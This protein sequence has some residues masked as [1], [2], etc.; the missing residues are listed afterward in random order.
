[1]SSGVGVSVSAEGMAAGFFGDYERS[2]FRDAERKRN[3]AVKGRRDAASGEIGSR[4]DLSRVTDARCLTITS[5]FRPD[6]P[7]SRSRFRGACNGRRNALLNPPHF[8]HGTQTDPM[9]MVTNNGNFSLNRPILCSTAI[10]FRPSLLICCSELSSRR[11]SAVS[12][13]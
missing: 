8:P 11:T 7:N 5:S 12:N 13:P 3:R 10:V 1:M 6:A 2:T 4:R 9:V